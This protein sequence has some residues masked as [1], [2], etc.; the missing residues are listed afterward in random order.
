LQTTTR[1]QRKPRTFKNPEEAL[2]ETARFYR[3]ALWTDADCYVEVWLEK[4]ALAS[5]VYDVTEDFDVNLMVARGYASLSFLHEAAAAISDEDRPAYIYHLGDYDP[6]GV[7]AADKIEQTLKEFA[8]DAEIHFERLAVLPWQ[9]SAWGLPTR[10]TKQ[11]DSRAK[12][13]G[14][15][16]VELDAID[17]NRLRDI[18]KAAIEQH[19]PPEH[20]RIIKVAEQSER[21]LLN[22]WVAP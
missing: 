22:S 6:S 9:I 12:G 16:S 19:L 3:K 20:Y 7:N 14:N 4:D 15:V 5:V 8:P 10:P 18:T 17:P 11:T 21:Q 2:Q 1:W 13:F